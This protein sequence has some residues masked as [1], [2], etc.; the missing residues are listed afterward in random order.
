M[1]SFQFSLSPSDV[2]LFHPLPGHALLRVLPTPLTYGSSNLVLPENYADRIEKMKACRMGEIVRVNYKRD[3]YLHPRQHPMAGEELVMLKEGA[4][5]W[6]LG[7]GDE[8]E[9][10]YVVVKHGQI[11]AVEV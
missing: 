4:R 7:H 2:P 10:E 3:K 8:M 6:Y 5:V 11:L 1:P 9:N